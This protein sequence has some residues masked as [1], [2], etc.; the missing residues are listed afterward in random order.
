[1]Q[2]PKQESRFTSKLPAPEI[3]SKMEE[4]AKPL[5]FN[6]QKQNYKVKVEIG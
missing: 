2:E 3:I 6:V 1:M 5:G 4:T